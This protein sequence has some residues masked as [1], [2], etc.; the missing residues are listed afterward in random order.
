MAGE[1]SIFSMLDMDAFNTIAPEVDEIEEEL[2]DQDTPDETIDKVIDKAAEDIDPEEV[3]GD[4]E[5][6]DESDDKDDAQPNLYS[7]LA[8]VLA[9]DGVLPSLTK[10]SKVESVDDLI[11]MI[12]EEI[13]KSEYADLN[14]DQRQYLDAVRNGVPPEEFKVQQKAYQNLSTINDN[15][16]EENE[17]LRKQ[18]L[19]A[20]FQSKGYTPE[21]AVKL[22]QR[23]IDIGE[24]VED[25][26]EALDYLKGIQKQQM[27]VQIKEAEE[28]KRKAAEQSQKELIKFKQTLD[29][30]KEFIPGVKVT[31]QIAQKVYEQATKAVAQGPNGQPINVVL[32]A[33]MD[34][35][36]E[37][38]AKLNYLFYVTKGFKDF[39]KI[40]SSQKS[41]A[42]RELDDFVKGNTFSPKA[43]DMGGNYDYTPKELKGGFDESIINNII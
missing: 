11:S 37:F 36:I 21:K 4:D 13:K 23:S 43:S 7:S 6:E 25:A 19:I 30:T 38:E 3:G 39:S 32:K 20:D 14:E 8:K 24:D 28:T 41:K 9:E 17:E 22:A 31:P 16:I 34:N 5:E 1:D 10:D 42:V 29:D 2:E 15:E 26:K 18:L 35:P 27:Q 40:A 12:R 33:K